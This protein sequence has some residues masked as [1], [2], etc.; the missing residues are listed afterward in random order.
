M[1][2]GLPRL[3][4]PANFL[5]KFQPFSPIRSRTKQLNSSP[6]TQLIS[7]KYR[8]NSSQLKSATSCKIAKRVV[9]LFKDSHHNRILIKVHLIEGFSTDFTRREL[10][11]IYLQACYQGPLDRRL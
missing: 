2:M 9:I 10:C 4:L 11:K 8:T 7:A 5:Y 6:N 3:L 1:E